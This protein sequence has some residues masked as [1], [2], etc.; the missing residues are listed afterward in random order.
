M[1]GELEN[2][3][4]T[5]LLVEEQ[6]PATVTMLSCFGMSSEMSLDSKTKAQTQNLNKL[7]RDR[8]EDFSFQTRPVYNT[9]K[10]CA[11]WS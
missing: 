1:H 9:M 4:H 10:V 3:I 7:Y 5:G 2:I 8:P 11:V 6:Q